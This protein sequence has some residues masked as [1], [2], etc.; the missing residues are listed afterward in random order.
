LDGTT[1]I[2]RTTCLGKPSEEQKENFTRILT[3]VIDLTT[4]SFP[5]GTAGRQLDT[6]ARI[7]LW[8]KGLNFGHGI[9]HGIGTY[10]NVHEGPHAI[11]YYRCIG[12]AL[13]PGMITTI[14]PGFYKENEY[15]IRTENVALVVKDEE[16][17]SKDSEF[18]KFETLTLC[19][20]DLKLIEK[21][22]MT[23]AEAT[24][25]NSYHKK[26]FET[27]SPLLNKEEANW[28]KVATMEI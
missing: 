27:L 11:S 28:L 22:L 20:I 14:E 9:G 24:W 16:K 25:L 18:F 4:T 21:E 15:G 23:E 19:P 8:K 2:T 6:I 12:I 17:S 10:L 3:G 5:R 13:E 7:P 26:V 1:D